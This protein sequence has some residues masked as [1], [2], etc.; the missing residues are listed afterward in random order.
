[1]VRK[2][3]IGFK[4]QLLTLSIIGFS[5]LIYCFPHLSDFFVYSRQAILNG[6]LWRLFTAPFVHF[7]TSH[8]FWDI[9]VFGIAGFSVSISGFPRFWI[10]CCLVVFIPGLLF[11][12]LFPDLEYYGGLSGLATG[13]VAYY[14]LCNIFLTERRRQIW[15]I[16]LLVMGIKI[17]IETILDKSIFVYTDIVNFRIL[18]LAHIVGYLGA[19]ATI[20]WTCHKTIFCRIR[21]NTNKTVK[22]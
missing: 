16:L 2:R 13:A 15:L 8:I 22:T 7:S 19:I 18:H 4:G 3:K 17:C 14:C 1:M 9:L 5:I 10:V 6:E 11:L 20:V 21:K 12:L